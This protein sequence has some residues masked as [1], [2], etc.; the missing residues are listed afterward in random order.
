MGHGPCRINP[1]IEGNISLP[2]RYSYSSIL[3]DDNADIFAASMLT[4]YCSF[5]S[6]ILSVVIISFNSLCKRFFLKGKG[7]SD[8]RVV[9]ITKK[10]YG[11]AVSFL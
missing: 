8:A 4:S 9:L 5:L 6:L 10:E 2:V 1:T 7:L 3:P 11:F